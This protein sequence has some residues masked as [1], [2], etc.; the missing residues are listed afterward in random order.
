MILGDLGADI[1]RVEEAGPPTGRR[2]AQAGDALPEPGRQGSDAAIA[3]NALGR[4]KRSIALNLKTEAAREVLYA[5]VKSADVLIEENRPAVKHRLGIDYERLSALNPRLVYCSLT[6]YGQNGPFAEQA[7]H[8]LN[9][10]ALSGC[11]SLIGP[12]GG[13]PVIP[14]NL[15]GD[16]GGG[17]LYATIGILA[18]LMARERTGRGQFVDSAMLDGVMLQMAQHLSGFFQTGRHTDRGVSMLG[19]GAPFYNVYETADGGSVTIAD[20]DPWFFAA[21]CRALGCEEYIP[22]QYDGARWLEMTDRFRAIFKTRTRDEWFDYLRRFDVCVAPMLELEEAVTHPHIL[23]R[24][25]VTEL[26]HPTLGTVRQIGPSVKLSDTPATIRS[27]AP[28]AGEHTDQ[29]LRALG[30]G[31]EAI[32]ELRGQGAVA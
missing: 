27:L 5:L 25:L 21:T 2:A 13:P 31:E 26:D 22:H 24:G 8:D 29:V 17:G 6:G 28:R 16:F 12:A 11:L 19:G 1:L 32:T 9:Y 4:N 10:L 23:A 14:L 18:A 20:T 15:I 7:G 3:F 30:Y